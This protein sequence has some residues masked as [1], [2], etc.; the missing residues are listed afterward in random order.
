M[1]IHKKEL[2]FP[3][4]VKSPNPAHAAAV[5]EQ[6][7]GAN[8]ELKACL[9]YFAQSFSTPD[10]AIRDLLMDI[11]TEEISHLE[12]VGECITQLMG[13]TDKEQK[14]EEMGADERKMSGEGNLLSD[15]KNQINNMMQFNFNSTVQKSMILD[16][17][18]LDFVDSSG[19]P[20]TGNFIN[21]V[22]DLV[23]NLQSD[24]AAELRAKKVYE[25]LYRH[26]DDPGAREMFQFLIDRE[27]AHATL[28]EEAIMR[29]KEIENK[30]AHKTG[31]HVN[32]YFDLSLGGLAKN[33]FSFAKQAKVYEGPVEPKE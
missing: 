19:T 1:Y 3:V 9:Q 23:A 25:E 17:H 13:G 16:G 21:N 29:A 6:F 33:E 10:P 7:G 22:G 31:D 30:K 5:L 20:F 12:M 8:G 11:S 15:A 27:A 2:L 24:L 26:V 18:G 28:F 4:Q 32:M 14:M